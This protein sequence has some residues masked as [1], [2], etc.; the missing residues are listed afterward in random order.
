MKESQKYKLM[1]LIEEIKKL[2]AMILLHRNV[3]KETFMSSQYEAKK[4]KLVGEI[5]DELVSPALQSPESFSL[6]QKILSK[7]YPPENENKISDEG[8]EQLAEAI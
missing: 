8:I 5:I 2:D 1:D 4:V 6:I 3:G 7:F